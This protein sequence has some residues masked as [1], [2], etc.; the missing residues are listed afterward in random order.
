MARTS[1]ISIRFAELNSVPVTKK[2]KAGTI[3]ADFAEELG[4]R[5]TNLFV[6]MKKARASYRL[7]KD[8][9]VAVVGNIRGGC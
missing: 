2:V 9:F 1:S 6:N 7:K 8:D 5:T 3:L 4:V